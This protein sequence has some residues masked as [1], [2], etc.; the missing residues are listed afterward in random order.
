M[1]CPLCAASMKAVEHM[2]AEVERLLRLA[3]SEY[4]RGLDDGRKVE[5]AGARR[6]MWHIEQGDVIEGQLELF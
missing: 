2:E 6:V 3:V 4:A 1:S 5:I